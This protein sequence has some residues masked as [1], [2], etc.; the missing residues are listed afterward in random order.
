M[1]LSRSYRSDYGL[2]GYPWEWKR[3]Q[4]SCCFPGP[5][6]LP[7]LSLGWR[8]TCPHAR[9]PRNGECGLQ[10]SMDLKYM[11]IR[12]QEADTSAEGTRRP[13]FVFLEETLQKLKILGNS[14]PPAKFQNVQNADWILDWN[15]MQIGTV[16]RSVVTLWRHNGIAVDTLVYF[17]TL[18]GNLT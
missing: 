8:K 17:Q 9:R 6:K 5:S 15:H 16:S 11:L 3:A 4:L 2:P 18:L 1:K 7:W 13:L 10:Q 12:K 14:W